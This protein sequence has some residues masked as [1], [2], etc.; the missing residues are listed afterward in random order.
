MLPRPLLARLL[1]PLLQRTDQAAPHRARHVRH[2]TRR[3]CRSL[4]HER[5]LSLDTLSKRLGC[6]ATKLSAAFQN[7]NT[8]AGVTLRPC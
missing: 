2:E 3:R 6:Q 8:S 4:D 7:L 1:V 5:D